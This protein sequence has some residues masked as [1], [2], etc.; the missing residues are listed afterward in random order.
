VLLWSVD[1]AGPTLGSVTTTRLYGDSVPPSWTPTVA[2]IRGADQ[3]LDES[4]QSRALHGYGGAVDLA[5][6]LLAPG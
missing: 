2:E 4:A 1:V 5:I 3:R 6:V